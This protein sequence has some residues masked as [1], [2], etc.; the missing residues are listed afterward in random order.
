VEKRSSVS[1]LR[2]GA[3]TRRGAKKILWLSGFKYRKSHVINP[4][5]GAGT[6]YQVKIIAHYGSG[7]DSGEDVYLSSHCREDFGDVRFTDDDGVT[8]LD[9]WMEEK[10]DSDYAVFWVEVADDLSSQSQTIYIYYGKSDATTTSNGANTFIFFDDF[11]GTSIDTT[12]WTGDIQYASVSGGILTWYATVLGWKYISTI[13]TFGPYNVAMRTRTL[14][15]GHHDISHSYMQGFTDGTKELLREASTFKRLR[16]Y[17]T[18]S[19]VVNSDWTVGAYCNF[20]IRWISSTKGSFIE[21]DV[22]VLNS[23]LTTQIPTTA[24]PIYYRGYQQYADG[25]VLTDWILIRKIVDPEPSHGSWGSEE[26][27]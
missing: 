7:T 27:Y 19:K 2:K 3:I 25:K 13:S 10:V 14:C 16:A 24:L 5:S 22:E 12:K 15:E 17:D 20:E 9:Y 8:E 23:P 18:A 4:A 6:N 1:L 26:R 11:L 21:N